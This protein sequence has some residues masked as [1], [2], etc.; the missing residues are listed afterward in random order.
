MGLTSAS[1]KIAEMRVV[2]L[3]RRSGAKLPENWVLIDHLHLLKG[4]GVDLLDRYRKLNSSELL[5]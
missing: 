3:L 1:D 5:I 2:N 4:I